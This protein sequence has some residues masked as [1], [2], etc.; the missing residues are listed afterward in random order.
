M[1]SGPPPG[2]LS[3]VARLFAASGTD[4]AAWG[5]AW[6]R[7]APAVA[8]VP[9]FGL[10]ALPGAARATLGL[11]LAAC[12][13]P[14]LRPVAHAETAWP[15]LLLVEAARGLPI[16]IAAAV[17]LWAATMVGG[18]VDA[19]RGSQEAVS[20]PTVEGRPTPLGVL[21]ALTAALAF[22]AT[23]GP[24]HVAGALAVVSDVAAPLARAAH[25]LAA[26]ISVAVALASPLVAASIVVEIAGAL[27]A[28]A[29]SPAQLHAW[30]APLRSL[31]VLALV[32]LLFDRIARGIAVSVAAATH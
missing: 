5:L 23:G 27:V 16:A 6:A 32:A 20:M 19:L 22:F 21:F 4:L 25:D 24:A 12:I 10:R 18:V 29:A 1:L 26:G 30:L 2:L 28:R 11:V 8:I 15:L 3:E 31:A 7:V 13:A 17:P 9:A 14:A